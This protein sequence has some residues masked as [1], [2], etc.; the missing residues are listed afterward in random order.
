MYLFDEQQF[1]LHCC[2]AYNLLRQS[3]SQRN[4]F[5]PLQYLFF[6][7]CYFFR[8]ANL[9]LNLFALMLNSSLTAIANDV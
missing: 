7:I 8:L 2:S 9:I 4:L 6:L 5:S 3:G 1:K